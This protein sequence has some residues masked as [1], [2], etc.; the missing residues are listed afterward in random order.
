MN[1]K[2]IQI[3]INGKNYNAL[4][5]EI[6]EKDRAFLK[7]AYESAPEYKEAQVTYAAGLIFAKKEAEAQRLENDPHRQ[8]IVSFNGTHRSSDGQLTND[9]QI[10]TRTNAAIILAIDQFRSKV[11]ALNISQN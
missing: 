8:E 9:L 7:E 11:D 5:Q 6:T 4:I 3:K 2:T 1:E 10:D